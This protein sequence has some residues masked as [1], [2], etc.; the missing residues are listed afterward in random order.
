MCLC[1]FNVIFFVLICFNSSLI[2]TRIVMDVLR[3]RVAGLL[4]LDLNHLD[5]RWWSR[6]NTDRNKVDWN[7]LGNFNN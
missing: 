1:F 3:L 2:P 4:L 7:I 6:G 5:W